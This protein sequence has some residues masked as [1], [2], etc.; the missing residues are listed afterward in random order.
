MQATIDANAQSMKDAGVDIAGAAAEQ[1]AAADAE[2]EAEAEH[3]A[4]SALI[5]KRAAFLAR[6]M[7]LPP[8]CGMEDM[9]ISELLA[10]EG[11]HQDSILLA[12][13]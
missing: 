12:G 6:L 7:K 11:E 5:M 10:G 9:V 4:Q 2:A 1:D 13:R 8:E 3:H